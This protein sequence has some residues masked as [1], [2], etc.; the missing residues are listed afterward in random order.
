MGPGSNTGNAPGNRPGARGSSVHEIEHNKRGENHDEEHEEAI[1]SDFD[2]RRLPR[3]PRKDR[4]G[5]D[6]RRDARNP[7]HDA[8]PPHALLVCKKPSSGTTRKF[9]YIR[10][11]FLQMYT[12][13]SI[14]VVEDALVWT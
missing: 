8:S 9:F 12:L 2:T 11:G 7:L 13:S 10:S 14:S 1:G 4:N 3:G 6:R 5:D